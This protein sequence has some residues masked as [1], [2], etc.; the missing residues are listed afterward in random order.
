MIVE[1]TIFR[2]VI[3]PWAI[4][5]QTFERLMPIAAAASSIRYASG[6]GGRRPARSCSG[7]GVEERCA[8]GMDHT[9]CLSRQDTR[10]GSPLPP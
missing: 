7:Y 2:A 10:S 9:S 1:P 5:S 6:S 8:R 4:R 3:W